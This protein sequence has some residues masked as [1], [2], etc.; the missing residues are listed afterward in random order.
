MVAKTFLYSFLFFSMMLCSSYGQDVYDGK[1]RVRLSPE[2]NETMLQ[3]NG[4]IRRQSVSAEKGENISIGLQSVDALNKT[5]RARSIR[6]VFPYAGIHEAKQ[7]N[8][9][10][11]LWYE[12]DLD[13]HENVKE[14]ARRYGFDNHIEIAEPVY[15]V[16]GEMNGAVSLASVV[17]DPD[18]KLQWHYQNTGQT[19]GVP[20]ADIHLPE[21]WAIHTGRP[22]VVVA[23]IDGGVDHA[24]YDIND[25]MWINRAEYNGRTGVDDDGNGY[26]DD[27]Y[28]YNFVRGYTYGLI[29]PTSHGTH[30]AGTIAAVNNNGTGV[31]GIAG[32]D[33]TRRGASIMTCQIF[34]EGENRS[35]YGEEAIAY[36]ANNGAVILQ[37]SWGYVE[38]GVF[39]KSME[40]AI[41]Y[42]IDTA[43]KD[44]DGKPRRNT[45][46]AG[47]IVIFAAGNSNS[48]GDWYPARYNRVISVASVN[49]YGKRAYYSNYG[50]WVSI[51]APGGDTRE[52][53]QGGIYSTLPNNKYGYMQGTSM[54]CPHVSGVAAL[55]L[56]RFG[57]E[58]YTPAM[59][60]A[61]L[62]NTATSLAEFDPDNFRNMGAGLVNAENAL[63]PDNGIPPDAINDIQASAP[64]STS[65][66]LSW[67]APWDADNQ[68]AN[69]YRVA[70][71]KNPITAGNFNNSET[72]VAINKAKPAGELEEHRIFG[73]MPDNV[74]YAAVRSSDLW[75]NQSL[76]SNV[77]S[78]VPVNHPPQIDGITD[79]RIRDVG[80]DKIIDLNTVFSDMDGD[81]LTFTGSI[82]NSLAQISITGSN[83]TIHPV[84]AGISN[85]RITARDPFGLSVS[86]D[87]EITISE[88]R[89][90]VVTSNST[91]VVL[92]PNKSEELNLLDYFSDPEDDAISF[93]LETSS[94]LVNVE[95]TG[96]LF[97]ITALE[98]GSARL[99]VTGQ[100]TYGAQS[101]VFTVDVQI[102]PYLPDKFNKLLI[103]PVP[104]ESLLNYSF[105]LESDSEVEIRV[106]DMIGRLVFKTAK[107]RYLQGSHAATIDMSGWYHGMYLIQLLI[108]EKL[109]D[110][111]KIVN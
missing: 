16:K 39:P 86:D 15:T 70:I 52:K 84:S 105:V 65:I 46:M 87:F 56:S 44:A 89:A 61:R 4:T 22:E 13:E 6:R 12:I 90:P 74:Y 76:I 10:L 110:T 101:D 50:N 1:I 83:L 40:T 45:P 85:I 49:H 62:L 9:G 73:L 55:I 11:H 5:Y 21:A 34:L 69:S 103:Y 88:N 20:G 47:G 92:K 32:G 3:T 27:I 28:G 81:E 111:K 41:N 68:K 79:V 8:Y 108:N 98:H 107:T 75:G 99:T 93:T 48:Y 94:T 37:N 36:A 77:V 100:D 109:Q 25:N 19:G 58:N 57:N 96:S 23:V 31:S 24:H 63:Q 38:E 106:I 2:A 42:F 26:I 72:I 66:Q 71:S 67:T 78:F 82:S 59:L 60:R 33:G 80:P 102:D 7:V 53:R 30:V 95:I 97:K 29:L 64:L 43:G 17:N 51:S 14:V 54:A 91:L 18:F 35:S 104:V